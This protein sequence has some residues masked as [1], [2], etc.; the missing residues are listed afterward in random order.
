MPLTPLEEGYLYEIYRQPL[1]LNDVFVIGARGESLQGIS[2][3]DTEGIRRG[4]DQAIDNINSNER[5][6]EAVRSLLNEIYIG[7]ELRTD[8]SSINRGGY[9]FTWKKNMI[10]LYEVLYTW[11]NIRVW[12]ARDAGRTMG[13]GGNLAMLG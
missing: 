11:T 6:V 1:V 7:Q 3:D 2:L 8:R 13:G 5:N 9:S 12:E 10:N 4:L